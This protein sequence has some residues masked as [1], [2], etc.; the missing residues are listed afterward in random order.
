MAIKAISVAN[1]T[2]RAAAVTSAGLNEGLEAARNYKKAKMNNNIQEE[3]RAQMG[4]EEAIRKI[5][6]AEVNLNQ[7]YYTVLKNN[8]QAAMAMQAAARQA[9]RQ[10][11]EAEKRAARRA[12]RR[13]RKKAAVKTANNAKKLLINAMEKKNKAETNIMEAENRTLRARNILILMRNQT[14]DNCTTKVSDIYMEANDEKISQ[15]LKRK[16]ESYK[17]LT[18]VRKIVDNILKHQN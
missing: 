2:A 10:A 5:I 12:T 15:V 1:N 6:T 9:K 16:R 13:A 14:V 7:P 11:A 17:A 3:Q 8:W 18:Y 4:I